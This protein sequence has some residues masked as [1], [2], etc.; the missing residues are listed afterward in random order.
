[1]V[2]LSDEDVAKLWAEHFPKRND[3]AKSKTL[4]LAFALMVENL[5]RRTTPQG[6]WSD[7]IHRA[8]VTLGVPKADYEQLNPRSI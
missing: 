3:D 6:D 5:A 8:C 2:N 1:M 7:R 4:I